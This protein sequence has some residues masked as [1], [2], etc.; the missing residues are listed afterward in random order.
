MILMLM[1]PVFGLT[2]QV[3]GILPE[4]GSEN[5]VILRVQ[6]TATTLDD[7]YVVI[8]NKGKIPVDLSGWILFDSY[9][10]TYRHLTPLERMANNPLPHMYRI[11][12]GTLLKSHSWIRICSGY[13]RNNEDYLY[14]NLTTQWLNDEGDTLY[15][16]D[17]FGNLISEFSW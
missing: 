9:Y 14:R 7:E 3:H 1:V 2:Q 17:D 5:V 15:L 12:Y 4:E 10:E 13:G 16:M 8:Y 11:P 6:Y